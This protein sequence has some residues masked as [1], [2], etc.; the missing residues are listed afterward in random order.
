MKNED[1]LDTKTNEFQYK[2]LSSDLKDTMSLQGTPWDKVI[3][4]FNPLT[5]VQKKY[6]FDCLFIWEYGVI[7]EYQ[8]VEKCTYDIALSSF[9]TSQLLMWAIHKFNSASFIIITLLT[10]KLNS[11]SELKWMLVTSVRPNPLFWF[12]SDIEIHTA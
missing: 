4:W 11:R 7:K 12:R 10:F 2:Y 8:N 6:L 5:Y 1:L 3:P 9:Y